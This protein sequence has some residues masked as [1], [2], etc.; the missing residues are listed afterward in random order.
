MFSKSPSRLRD[1]TPMRYFGVNGTQ[2]D[3][4]QACMLGK[5]LKVA[6]NG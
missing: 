5:Y 4:I 3:E 1:T 2:C 6:S